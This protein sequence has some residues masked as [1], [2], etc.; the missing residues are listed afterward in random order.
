MS[1]RKYDFYIAGPMSGLPE[2]GY[3]AF[4]KA[5]ADLTGKGFSV[6][7]PARLDKSLG[8]CEDYRDYY[9]RDIPYLL[10]S[11]GIVL[12]PGWERSRGAKME[13]TIAATIGMKVYRYPYLAEEMSPA[14]LERT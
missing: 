4:F 7:N 6:F 3:P 11:D 1:K 10:E 13:L 2:H 9:R 5:E 14:F 12:L 8:P